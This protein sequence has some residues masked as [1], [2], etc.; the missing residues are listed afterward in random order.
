MAA[1]SDPTHPVWK[2]VRVAT[3]CLV[4]LTLQWVTATEYNLSLDG[5]AGTL[6]GV[7]LMHALL[8][9]RRA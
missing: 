2:C 8:E 3:L 4:L 7:M 9:F 1:F 5:E 6:A